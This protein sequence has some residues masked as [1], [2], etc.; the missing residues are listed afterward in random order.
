MQQRKAKRESEWRQNPLD[1]IYGCAT[2]WTKALK[3]PLF[4]WKKVLKH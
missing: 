4:K 2:Q 3:L 1:Y